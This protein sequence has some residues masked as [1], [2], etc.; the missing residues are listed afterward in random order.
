MKTLNTKTQLPLLTILITTLLNY[1]CA[2]ERCQL[3]PPELSF[4][5]LNTENEPL[6]TTANYQTVKISYM[7]ESNSKKYISDL[8]I[9]QY[10]TT[11]SEYY[12]KSYELI[13]K[14]HNSNSI[15]FTIEINE[16]PIGEL[17]LKNHQKQRQM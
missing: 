2:K 3:P 15:T 14:A 4:I 17:K 8:E 5:I 11:L 13:T 1:S 12:G 16:D 10:S 7:G 9:S 6:I